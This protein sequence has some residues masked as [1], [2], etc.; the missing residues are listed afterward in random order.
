MFRRMF[1]LG[2]GASL[3]LWGRRR[4]Q[5]L[6]DR[7]MP[8]TMRNQASSR[9]QRLGRDLRGAVGD[10]RT[11]MRERAAGLRGT[12][13]APNGLRGTDRANGYA[14]RPHRSPSVG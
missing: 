3:A 2:A 7:F 14:D 9:A 8:A 4:A 11:A 10:G 1:W 6:A 13:E 5:E 12:D